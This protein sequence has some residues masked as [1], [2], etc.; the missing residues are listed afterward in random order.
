MRIFGFLI[1]G[2][3]L[4]AGCNTTGT[5]SGPKVTT[6][7]KPLKV[8]IGYSINPDCSSRG[9]TDIRVLAGPQ[10]GA[11]SVRDGMDFP[12]FKPDNTRHHCN[13]RRVPV[14]EIVYTP[15]GRYVGPDSFEVEFVFP[16]GNART[17]TYRVE[18]R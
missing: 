18:A 9:R 1:L 7:G 15:A 14:T 10:H 16:T 4:L 11:V 13:T 2:T 12:A 17:H 6:G 5:V 8:D 3:V